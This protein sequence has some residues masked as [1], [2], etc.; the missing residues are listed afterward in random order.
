ML[1]LLS[2]DEG[3]SKDP[4]AKALLES[5]SVKHCGSWRGVGAERYVDA[6]TVAFYAWGTPAKSHVDQPVSID[7]TAISL[8]T[9]HRQHLQLWARCFR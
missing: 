5:D 6:Q 3:L 2:A 7:R 1:D 9:S 8:R 4:Q